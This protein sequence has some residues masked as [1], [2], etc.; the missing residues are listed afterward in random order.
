V[1]CS[2]TDGRAPTVEQRS[3]E[4]AVLYTSTADV[5]A[6]LAMGLAALGSGSLAML[7][8]ASRGGLMTVVEIF[9]LAILRAVHRDRLRRFRFG[10]GKV[11]QIC[12]LAIGAALVASGLWIAARLA[13]TLLLGPAMV[14]PLGLA[15]AAFA[16]SL[17]LLIN[18]LGWLAMAAARRDD[19]PIY[20]AQLRAR[21]VKLGSSLF[22]Q[23]VL[24]IAA[25]STD[26]LVASWLDAAGAAFVSCLML[27]TG[28]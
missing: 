20:R 2:T 13:G 5:G 14:L 18:A 11:E 15:V 26:P 23:S 24:T 28:S 3:K 19:S 8:E 7:G 25:L 4:R 16:N 27:A 9:A 12:N 22:L 6:V 21:S 10:T 17:D 1:T